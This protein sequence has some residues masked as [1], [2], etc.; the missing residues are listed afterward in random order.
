MPYTL[1]PNSI[2]NHQTRTWK[3]AKTLYTIPYTLYPIPYNL[4]LSTYQVPRAQWNFSFAPGFPA[5]IPL[6]FT[7]GTCD[8]N[9]GLNPILTPNH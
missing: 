6:L 7:Y 8:D 4:T 5:H 2:P 3:P 9:T 1:Y